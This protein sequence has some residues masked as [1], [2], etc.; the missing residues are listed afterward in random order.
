[1]EKSN[2]FKKNCELFQNLRMR[3]DFFEIIKIMKKKRTKKEVV[4]FLFFRYYEIISHFI[5]IPCNTLLKTILGGVFMKKIISI[6]LCLFIGNFML[7]GCMQDEVIIKA[8]AS[9]EITEN[10]TVTEEKQT[11][12]ICVYVCGQVANPGVY[13][14]AADARVCDALE[15]AGGIL[16]DGNALVL[17]QAEHMTDGETIYVPGM[18]ENV[19][20]TDSSDDGKVNIN[21]ASKEELMTLPGIGESKADIIIEFREEH[22]A[23]QSIEEL[24]EIQGIKE[25]VFNKIKDYIKTS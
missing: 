6:F 18:D 11:E 14:V 1:M 23:F 8:E 21:T 2:N 17:K 15:M 12:Y 25:G 20:I 10:Q 7:I 4:K 5:L 16:E 24:M 3:V 19:E 22:G 13:Q 9:S